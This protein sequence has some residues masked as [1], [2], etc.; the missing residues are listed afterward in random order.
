MN[1]TKLA[2][3][4]VFLTLSCVCFFFY[5]QYGWM[6]SLTGQYDDEVIES[7]EMKSGLYGSLSLAFSIVAAIYFILSRRTKDNHPK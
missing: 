2:I 3:C 1:K 4:L 5:F 7:L 6:S